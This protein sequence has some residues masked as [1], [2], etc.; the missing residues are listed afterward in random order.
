M[1]HDDNIDYFQSG[2]YLNHLKK[3]YRSNHIFFGIGFSAIALTLLF[4]GFLLFSLIT[5]G[6][7]AF[8]KTEL[9]V[10]ISQNDLLDNTKMDTLLFQKLNVEFPDLNKKT[11]NSLVSP[12]AFQNLAAKAKTYHLLASDEIDQYLKSPE[13]SYLPQNQKNIIDRLHEKNYFKQK[14]NFNF[15]TNPDSQEAEE[16]G[17]AGALLGSIMLII[18]T[19]LICIPIGIGAAI[20]LEEFAPKNKLID[21]IEVNINNLAAIPS[22]VFGLL[23]LSV[24]L[25]YLHFPR[26][27][28]LVGGLVL[29]LM[30]LPPLIMNARLAIQNVPSSIK[31]AALGLGASPMQ[32]I[33]HHVLP[34]SLPGIM[35]G[36]IIGL[37]RALGETAPLLMIG[38]VAF[39]ADIPGSPLEASTALPVQIYMWANHP[40]AAFIEKS[41]GAILVLLFI[42]LL[43]NLIAIKI[44]HKFEKDWK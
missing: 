41:S 36:T 13:D 25:N 12:F 23:G 16:A 39:I 15:L 35:T 21:F 1:L 34:L 28:A 38:M 9:V 27:T 24:F 19:A 17:I 5:N 7:P 37:A 26:S 3:R 33:L 14:F 10:T 22:I 30:T 20:Y 6:L 18:I 32:V 31:S 2:R 29:S 8:Q 11:L 4:L 40:E 44:R 42:L 43:M